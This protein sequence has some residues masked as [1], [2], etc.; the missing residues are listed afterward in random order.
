MRTKLIHLFASALAIIFLLIS[1]AKDEPVPIVDPNEPEDKVQYDPTPYIMPKLFP[2]PEMVIPEDNPMTEQGVLLGRMLFYDPILD[3]DSARACATCHI[4][5]QSF[6]SG[7]IVLPHLN[8]AYNKN[9]LWDGHVSGTVEEV[10]YFEITEFFQ[11]DF[12]RINASKLYRDQFKR[13]FDTEVATPE[14]AAKAMAQFERILTSYNSKFDKM[15]RGELIF[16]E[17]ERAGM[18]L[19]FSEEADC[20]HCHNYLFFGDNLLHNNG[21]DEDPDEGHFAYTGNP[22]DIGKFK[23]PTLRNVALTAPYMH[24]GRFETLDEVI[25]FYSEQ[26]KISPTIDPLM[27]FMHQGGVQMSPTEKRQLKAFLLTLTDEAFITNPETQNP[28]TE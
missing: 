15:L 10:M 24:D 28:F 14:L 1:C 5:E 21:L 25:D 9:Y 13:A 7:A 17:D 26:V 4:Q 22:I 11:A 8:F 6:T 18:N 2:L 20:F 27:E 23:T 16:N 3:K 19:F 12:D